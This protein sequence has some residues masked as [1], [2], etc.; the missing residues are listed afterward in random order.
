MR[1]VRGALDNSI[2]LARYLPPGG[3]FFGAAPCRSFRFEAGNG[4]GHDR[5]GID[6]AIARTATGRIADQTAT[7]A[8]IA[9]WH[10]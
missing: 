3:L 1:G 7:G 5:A 9:G 8:L 10:T 4:S 6:G 2:P